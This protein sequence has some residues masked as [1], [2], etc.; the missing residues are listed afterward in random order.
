M[1]GLTG[2]LDEY[3]EVLDEL[4]SSE[5]ETEE[6]N[7]PETEEL[8]EV[9]REG[10]RPETWGPMEDTFVIPYRVPKTRY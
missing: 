10:R 1:G 2:R 7:E 3:E 5:P 9:R 4:L 6:L 8:A